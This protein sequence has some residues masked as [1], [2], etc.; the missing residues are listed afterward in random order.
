[1]NSYNTLLFPDTDIFSEKHYPLMLFFSPLHFLQLIEPGAGGNSDVSYESDLFVQ[2]GL[3]QA[4]TPAPLGENRQ[5]FLRLID[6]IRERKEYYVS[7]L[8]AMSIGSKTQN[9]IVSSLLRE[10]GVAHQSETNLELWQARLVLAIA[11]MLDAE[12]DALREQLSEQLAFFN[13]EEIAAFRSL[14]EAKGTNEEDFFNKLENIKVQLEN[15]RLSDTI[16][17]FEAWLRLLKNRPLPSVK[18]WLA[19]TRDSADQIF[20]RY[21]S[22]SDTS[23]IPLLKLA[24]PAY[25]DASAKYVVQQIEEFHQATTSIH[26]GL[27]ADFERIVKTA[28][29]ARELLPYD[30]DWAEKWEGM[31]DQYFPASRG[32]RNHIT[33]YL[34]PDQPLAR[35]IS[36]PE[37]IGTSHDQAAHGL[38]GI[39]SS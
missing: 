31:L 35:V 28:P 7:Q 2:H 9:G 30:T 14:Q 12:E 33:F 1:M 3:C 37:S 29:Y 36:L 6:N 11:E 27:V 34:L 16:K 21:E 26:Q 38:L 10:Y 32:G 15:P 25:I 8:R 39:R 17:R 19:S 24:F 4:H 20:K 5:Q 13:K 23:A 18:V 22:T